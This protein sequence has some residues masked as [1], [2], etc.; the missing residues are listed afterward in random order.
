MHRGHK[1]M[2]Q[3]ALELPARFDPSGVPCVDGTRAHT[4]TTS[5]RRNHRTLPGLS[6]T[7]VIATVEDVA[8]RGE[9][10]WLIWGSVG[11]RPVLFTVSAGAAAEMMHSVALGE[12]ATAIVEPRQLVLERLD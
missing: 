7:S 11:N 2:T 3:P 8:E 4:R 9:S 5:H 10:D 6:P 12:T 1:T